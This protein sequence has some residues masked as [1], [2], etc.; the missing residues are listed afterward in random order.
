MYICLSS[1]CGKLPNHESTVN[2]VVENDEGREDVP[3]ATQTSEPALELLKASA[4][5]PEPTF[6]PSPTPEPNE[7][8]PVLPY[9]VEPASRFSWHWWFPTVNRSNSI[10]KYVVNVG[11]YAIAVV[12][13]NGGYKFYRFV[14]P[15]FIPINKLDT[16]NLSATEIV[17]KGYKP[18]FTSSFNN[19][20]FDCFS[21]Y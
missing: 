11:I 5:E 8:V 21:S 19:G 12:V 7:S 14:N 1:G 3:T 18:C 16:V 13:I 2:T 10:T 17:F 6:T 9:S 4:S 15:K 20:Y